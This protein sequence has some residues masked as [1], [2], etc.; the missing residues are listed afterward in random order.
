MW[1]GLTSCWLKCDKTHKKETLLVHDCKNDS[2]ET[3]VCHAET[4]HDVPKVKGL[5]CG[6]PWQHDKNSMQPGWCNVICSSCTGA[7][8]H[9]SQNNASY[10]WHWV[11][12]VHADRAMPGKPCMHWRPTGAGLAYLRQLWQRPGCRR[13]GSRGGDYRP[14]GH[15]DTKGGGD[16][17][18][19]R[20]LRSVLPA[21]QRGQMASHTQVHLHA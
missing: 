19:Q 14:C 12:Q 5:P 21:G 18:G 9:I 7:S 15:T 13:G 20:L 17:P 11:V 1:T 2:R 16:R 8:P 10:I 6:T 3:H 4:C